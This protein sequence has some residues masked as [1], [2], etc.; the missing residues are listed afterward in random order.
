MF[1]NCTNLNYIDISPFEF[2][3]IEKLE[4]FNNL[5][6]TGHIKI[7]KSLY[8]KVEKFIPKNRVFFENIFEFF[9]F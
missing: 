9:F 8:Q 7:K 2:K 3:K 6:E 4:M 5:T 1:F